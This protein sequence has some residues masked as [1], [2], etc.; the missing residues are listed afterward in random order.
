MPGILGFHLCSCSDQRSSFSCSFP[1]CSCTEASSHSISAVFS[2]SPFIPGLSLDIIHTHA[3]TW[4]ALSLVHFVFCS[5]SPAFNVLLTIPLLFFLHAAHMLSSLCPPPA[6]SRIA[7][8]SAKGA[9]LTEVYKSAC[10]RSSL[11]S[12]SS[13]QTQVMNPAQTHQ[14]HLDQ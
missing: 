8:V 12:S 6:P 11:L 10:Q 1:A 5:T 2:F 4:Q 14:T 13:P 7:V 9:L 3:Y